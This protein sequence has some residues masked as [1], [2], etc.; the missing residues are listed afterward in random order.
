MVTAAYATVTVVVK[1]LPELLG[2]TFFR[3]GSQALA[4]AGGGTWEVVDGIEIA[5]VLEGVVGTG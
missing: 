2:Y 4:L 1:A 3:G 5:G